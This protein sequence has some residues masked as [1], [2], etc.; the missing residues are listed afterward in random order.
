MIKF[1][2]IEGLHQV[3]KMMNK[4]EQYRPTSPILYKGKIKLHGTNGGVAIYPD[5]RVVAQSREQELVNGADNAGFAKWVVSH[6]AEFARLKGENQVTVYGEWCGKGINKGCAIHN[7][8][9]HFA[10]F[11]IQ[12]GGKESEIVITDPV[13]I[14]LWFAQHGIDFVKVLPWFE[15][16]TITLDFGNVDQLRKQADEISALVLQVEACDPW[17]KEQFGVEG[18]GEGIVYYPQL[19]RRTEITRYMFKAKGAKHSVQ[20]HKQAVMVDPEIVKGVNEFV[21]MFVTENRCLQGLSVACNNEL[22][23]KLTGSFLKWV[24]QDVLK[25][26]K[27]ELEASNLTWEQV[28]GAVQKAAQRWWLDRTAR[29]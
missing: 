27:T 19:L 15:P 13:E 5:G 4:Y 10:V 29:I 22:D 20:V 14:N 23:R 9:K 25:E 1:P 18:V 8:D 26:S 7:V 12:I 3:V 17:V 24:C 21:N 11:M 6:E 2:E 16:A 28:S